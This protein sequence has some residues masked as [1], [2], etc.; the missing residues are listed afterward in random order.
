MYHTKQNPKIVQYRDYNKFNNECFRR[1]LLQE[2]SFRNVQPNEFDKLIAS[3]ILNSHAQLKE[4]YIRCNQ[5][6]FMNKELRKAI[7]TIKRLLNKLRKVNCPENQL[8]CKRQ[9]TLQFQIS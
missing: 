6:V 7:M 5:A 1:D 2:L 8:A 4:K 3:K 9:R